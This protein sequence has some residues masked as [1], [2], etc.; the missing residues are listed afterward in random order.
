[1]TIEYIALSP[2]QYLL[3]IAKQNSLNAVCTG[4]EIHM[5]AMYISE[6]FETKKKHHCIRY[7]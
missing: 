5:F 4:T 7:D 3:E 6:G 1:M 2:W